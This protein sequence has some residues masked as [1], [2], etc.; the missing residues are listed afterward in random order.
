MSIATTV[1]ALESVNAHTG[2]IVRHLILAMVLLQFVVVLLRYLFGISYMFMQEG[3]LYMHAFLFM[4][5]AGYTLLIDKHVRV[6]IFY[7]KLGPR[8]RAWTDLLGGLF[9]LLPPLFV[10]IYYS[11]PSVRNSWAIYEGAISVGGIPASFL[12][13]TLVPAFCILLILQ[14]L[15]MILRSFHFITRGVALPEYP[16]P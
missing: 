15:A 11:W 16:A 12:L 6:D 10:L 13:K 8:G 7:G 2:R 5:A 3:V 14:G 1:R 9:L 4:L